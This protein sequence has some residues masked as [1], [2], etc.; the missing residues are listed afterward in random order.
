MGYKGFLAVSFGRPKIG[1]CNI[2][3]EVSRVKR[4]LI[5]FSVR[6]CTPIRCRSGTWFFELSLACPIRSLGPSYFINSVLPTKHLS[7]HS[8]P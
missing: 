1:F 4:D 3:N 7:D 6:A 8:R 5:F 2:S